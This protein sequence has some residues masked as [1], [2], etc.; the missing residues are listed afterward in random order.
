M[1]WNTVLVFFNESK[2]DRRISILVN[3]GMRWN[4]RA[5]FVTI[6]GCFDSFE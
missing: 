1:T 3:Y 4:V 5:F 6:L 2:A